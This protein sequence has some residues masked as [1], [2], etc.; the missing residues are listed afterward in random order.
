MLYQFGCVV[1]F[2]NGPNVYI[3]IL[4]NIMLFV[5]CS[6]VFCDQHYILPYHYILLHDSISFHTN[7]SFCI[8]DI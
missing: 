7:I 2:L 6:I 4:F 5:M 1:L 3:L 8:K